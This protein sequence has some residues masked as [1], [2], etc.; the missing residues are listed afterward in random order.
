[1]PVSIKINIRERGFIIISV[2]LDGLNIGVRGVRLTAP[3]IA[4]GNRPGCLLPATAGFSDC[5]RLA[6]ALRR[7]ASKRHLTL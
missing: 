6:M 2:L 3:G 7:T 4:S 5:R 1:M